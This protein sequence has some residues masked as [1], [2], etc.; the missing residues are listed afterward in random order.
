MDIGVTIDSRSLVQGLGAA[1]NYTKRTLP[2]LINTSA[3]WVAVNAKNAMPFVKPEKIDAELAAVKAPVIGK[4]G[5]PLKRMLFKG[6]KGPGQRTEG[7][8]LSVL[9]IQ[10]R[11]NPESVYNV[12]TSGRY[13]LSKSPFAGVSRAAG[14]AAMRKLEDK[15]IKLRHKAGK[16]LLAGWVPVV[17]A[18]FPLSKQ[19]FIRGNG[20]PLE[21]ARNY[22]GSDLGSAKPALGDGWA[23][24]AVIANEV[25]A[26]GKQAASFNRALWLYGGPAAQGAVD[27]EGKQQ[28]EF[29][30]KRYEEELAREFNRK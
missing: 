9:I 4:R 21:G 29:A 7:A 17:R 12:L 1:A 15:L 25:G 16:F 23:G 30:L 6:R 11:A 19:R 10:A 3:Y 24:F 13:A 5:K 2:E 27:R 8:P 28:A 22:Y 20:A 18:L 26:K 14:R